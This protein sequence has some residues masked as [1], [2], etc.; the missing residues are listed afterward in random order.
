MGAMRTAALALCGS[1]LT[2]IVAG[3]YRWGLPITT[4]LW[5]GMGLLIFVGAFPKAPKRNAVLAFPETS[6]S[7]LYWYN[8]NFDHTVYVP[9]PTVI[10]AIVLGSVGLFYF[11]E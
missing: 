2:V 10:L 7:I 9:W 1:L 5:L 11:L 4:T 6:L 3:E 8:K